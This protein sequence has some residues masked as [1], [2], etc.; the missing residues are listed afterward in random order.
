ME[1]IN[2]LEN[3]NNTWFS[4]WQ[5]RRHSRSTQLLNMVGGYLMRLVW[6]V[7]SLDKRA[8]AGLLFWL[9]LERSPQDARVI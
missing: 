9:F 2:T 5:F 3:N 7:D 4:L 8:A 1:H 6:H